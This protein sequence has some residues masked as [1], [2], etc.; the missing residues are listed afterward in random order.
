MIDVFL[1][2]GGNIGDAVATIV[3]AQKLI[4]EL[5]GVCK[6]QSS[7]LYLTS[8]VSDI[9][10]ADYINGVCRLSTDL[11][12]KVLWKALQQIERDL[13]KVAKAK[14]EPRI[15]DIDILF[16]GDER[17]QD[18]ELTIPH[19][20]WKERLFVLVPLSELIYRDDIQ[21]RIKELMA[22]GQDRIELK[23]KNI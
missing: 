8:A 16:Y 23:E 10:Q 18:H 22:L 1:G 13:G 12:L 20:H 7:R 17:F 5:D 2:F 3:R 19:P 14:N 9:P 6:M 11:P 4:A 15:I 21:S